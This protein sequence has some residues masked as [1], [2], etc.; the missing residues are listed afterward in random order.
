MEKSI[1]VFCATHVK[2]QKPNNPIYVP[3]HVGKFGKEDLGYMGD[4]I[5]NNI[6]DLNYLFGELTGLFWIW[7]N[8]TGLDYVGLCHYRRYFLN[9]DRK[10]MN[11]E[12]YL[13]VL[14]EYDAIVPIR[15]KCD[16]SYFDYYGR[17]HDSAYLLKI[18]NIISKKFPDY[19]S[20]Y[21]SAMNGT[22]FYSGNLIVSSLEIVKNYSEWLFG[23]FLELTDDLDLTGYDDYHKRIFGFLSEQMF[24]VYASKNELK[25]KEIEVGIFEE[26]AETSRLRTEIQELIKDNKCEMAWKYFNDFL[27]KRPDVLLPGSDINGELRDLYNNLKVFMKEKDK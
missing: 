24:F 5:G 14:N 23:I 1:A 18:E 25:C 4:D 2:F 17:A 11:R 3:L 15:A 9:N 12:Q 7:Q 19:L 26:K 8:I 13:E 10:P 16:T 20:Y 27:D 21:K 6:S 22:L